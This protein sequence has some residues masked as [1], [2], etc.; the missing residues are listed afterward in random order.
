MGGS[1]AE[2]VGVR[3]I[4]TAYRAPVIKNEPVR[5]WNEPEIEKSGEERKILCERNMA[6]SEF[7]KTNPPKKEGGSDAADIGQ[8][9]ES[10]MPEHGK[11][12]CFHRFNSARHER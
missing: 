11:S 1:H 12:Q 7:P 2:I 9:R 5:A 10:A 3:M 4:C 8:R 6:E